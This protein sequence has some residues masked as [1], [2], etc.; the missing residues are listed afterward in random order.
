MYANSTLRTSG[1]HESDYG[2]H[3]GYGDSNGSG[4]NW[5]ANIWS[6]GSAYDGSHAGGGYGLGSYCLGWLR[7]NASD[8]NGLAGEG[9]YLK[10]KSV[11]SGGWGYNGFFHPRTITAGGIITGSD[12]VATS[13]IR[14]K[15]N[16]QPILGAAQKLRT[17]RTTTHDRIDYE[18][19]DG[20]YPRKASIIAQDF[21]EILP[22]SITYT[23]D[24]KLGKK[25][26]VSVPATVVM[27][28]AAVNEHTDTI[29][30][31]ADTIAEQAKTIVSLSERLERLEKAMLVGGL[32]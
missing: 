10:S 11:L 20:K 8:N 1:Y 2:S 16:L 28:I 12:A 7:D 26:N 24:E 17:V 5:G 14:V 19:V 32:I 25:L 6:M 18:M 27:T 9:I 3:G 22:E 31:Q 13:D 4:T 21:L 29:A 23:D 30:K 15:A